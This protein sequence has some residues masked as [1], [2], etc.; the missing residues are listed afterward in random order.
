LTVT[1]LS[2]RSVTASTALPLKPPCAGGGVG[3][4]GIVGVET[5]PDDPDPHATV[6]EANRKRRS[7][8]LQNIV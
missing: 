4:V 1:P 5:G 8:T 6:A 7:L 2:E 3:P